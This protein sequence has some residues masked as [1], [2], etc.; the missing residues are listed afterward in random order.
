[1][2]KLMKNR[3]HLANQES[4]MILQIG[5]EESEDSIAEARQRII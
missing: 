1:M 5:G 4:S 2:G 3:Y